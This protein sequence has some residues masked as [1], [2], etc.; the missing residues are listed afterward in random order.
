[1]ADIS[2]IPGPN[3][4]HVELA[5]SSRMFSVEKMTDYIEQKI[6]DAYQQGLIDGA[7][8]A[9]VDPGEGASE[10]PEGDEGAIHN[11]DLFAEEDAE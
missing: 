10:E 2:D 7:E 1:M 4:R 3:R 6:E 9:I 11:G 8:T 5:V